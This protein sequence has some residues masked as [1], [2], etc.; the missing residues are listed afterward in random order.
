MDTNEQKPTLQDLWLQLRPSI[1]YDTRG[2]YHK[3]ERDWYGMD[4]AQ[5]LRVYRII[6]RKRQ[7]DDYVNPNPCFALND[8][9]QEDEQLQAKLNHAQKKR[10]PVNLNCTLK[11]GTMMNNGTAEIAFYN[12]S[13]GVYSKEDIK[14][15]NLV[16]KKRIWQE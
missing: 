1:T 9:M 2:R 7:H 11:G 12:G 15:F 4:D 13:W 14:T 3:C 6:E 16:T 10:E 8:A 5:R